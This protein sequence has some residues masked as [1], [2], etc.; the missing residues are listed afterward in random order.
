[1]RQVVSVRSNAV[2]AYAPGAAVYCEMVCNASSGGGGEFD[3]TA[4]WPV[5]GTI[6]NFVV[7]LKVPPGVGNTVTST[8][9]KAGTNQAVT[10][11]ISGTATTNRDVTNSFHIN[12]GELLSI[13]IT[14]TGTPAAPGSDGIEFVWEF[15]GD[16]A[17]ESGYAWAATQ[18][19]PG[20][21]R[22]PLIT[23][24]Y[25]AW[26][27]NA[28]STCANV[29]GTAGTITGYV[30]RLH[31]DSI[32]PGGEIYF[33]IYRST[34]LIAGGAF[35]KQD[36]TGGT[37]NCRITFTNLDG[38]P[39]QKS[40]TFTLP[41]LPGDRF[42]L[43]RTNTASNTYAAMVSGGVSFIAT[44]DGESMLCGIC[45]ADMDPLVTSYKK[46]FSD[47][48][49]AWDS[50][51]SGE[52]NQEQLGGV[53]SFTLSGLRLAAQGSPGMG[54]QYAL[55]LRRNNTSPAGTTR[56]VLADTATTA[57][58][59]T[60]AGLLIVDGDRFALRAVPS[61]TPTARAIAWA[62]TMGIGVN[63]PPVVNAGPDQAIALPVT[64]AL[65]AGTA[66]DDGL[67]LV[68]GALTITWTRTS[69]P[70]AVTFSDATSLTPLVT[71]MTAVGTYVLRLTVTDGALTVYDEMTVV[72][73]AVPPEIEFPAASSE[74]GL[75]W[76]EMYHVDAA[77]AP[78]TFLHAPVD[79]NDPP[80]YFGGYKEPRVLG[81]GEITRALSDDRGQ[82][83]SA[84]FSW[85]TSDTDRLQ[86]GWMANPFQRFIQNRQVIL[87]MISDAS[88][89]LFLTPR[90][91]VRGVIRG[92]K[93]RG[94]K[95]FE[96]RAQDFVTSLFGPANL[97]KQIPQEAIARAQF[98][99]CPTDA[100]G[101]PVPILFGKLS[102]DLSAS[103]PPVL[104]G[105]AARGAY[106][107][108]GGALVAGFGDLVSAASIPTNPTV[109][110]G[111]NGSG[112]LSAA[113]WN[114]Q[115][116]AMVTAVD[117]AGVETD[118]VPF[119]SD[120][121]NGGSRGSFA[122]GFP[123][124]YATVNGTQKVTVAWNASALA[125]KYRVY[126]GYYYY[127]F[128]PVVWKEVVA[129]TVTVDFTAETDGTLASFF[130][131]WTYSVSAVLPDG[132]T[133]LS[134][135][136][137][138]I[139]R[140]HR[141]KIRVQ[142]LAVATATAYR[143]RRKGATGDW[144]RQWE[145]AAPTLLFDDDLL[146]TGATF[147][148]GI[149]ALTGVV[150]VTY[151]G[152][153]Y[154][155]AGGA[156]HA[157]LVCGHQ[158]EAITAA[159]QDGVKIDVGNY[160]VTVLL[161]GETGY[162]TFF[163]THIGT[164]PY[165]QVNGRRYTKVYLRGPQGDAFADGSKPITLNLKGR[166]N[167]TGLFLEQL[168]D[169]YR[170][171]VV[172]FGFQDAGGGYLS[173]PNWPVGIDGVTTPQIDDASFALLKT[174]HALRLIGGYPGAIA[175]GLDGTFVTLR[176]ALAQLN[177]SADC[178]NGFNRNSQFFVSIFD[179]RP[180]VIAAGR[181]YT[182]V[183]DI[184][185]ESFDID[186]RVDD[187][188]NPVVYSFRKLYGAQ[189]DGRAWDIQEAEY[190]D[191]TAIINLRERRPG[192]VLDLYGVRNAAV[193]LDIARRRNVAKKEPPTLVE[194]KTTLQGLSTE[195]GD[196]ILVSHTDGASSSGWTLRPLRVRRHITNPQTYTVRM[197][198]EDVQRRLDELAIFG[199]LEDEAVM[200]GN[201]GDEL[202]LDAPLPGAYP[203]GD[204][205]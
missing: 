141:R 156:W 119:Y 23:G 110:A 144:D 93:P 64:Y 45:P 182:Q 4:P 170:E 160:G 49:G 40:A 117:A 17:K 161:P 71:G 77:N 99:R 31:A 41:C 69:G 97:Q 63:L 176:D 150:P 131:Q 140:T 20:T 154:D 11:T 14:A 113:I 120:G 127:G 197:V 61:A 153:E 166:R 9:R 59:P 198:C 158:V 121:P 126:L 28:G 112:T 187:V 102:N 46:L 84:E 19:N 43:E 138:G 1:M 89:R 167:S 149:A 103:A 25:V 27:T 143:I 57:S 87:R 24:S 115:W 175:F 152:I 145:V 22:L 114:A 70:T 56:A 85:V 5:P 30:I 54:R 101:K 80:F 111:A 181:P 135:E 62:L 200:D 108:G 86:R 98:P 185:K 151:I 50:S 60:S 204:E 75:S 136:V 81:F 6:D 34:P 8:V 190:E 10:T 100:V 3:V 134:Q 18:S 74:I 172:N 33:D 118:P 35:V 184:V 183:H 130:Q 139:V 90:T 38:A 65:M 199:P 122:N 147:I 13:E 94:P 191:G 48:A 165:H 164:P 132:E 39:W 83:E 188:E 107:D 194:L 82:Y 68:P 157:G 26:T 105:T 16:N 205:A 15:T 2:P 133:G 195:L 58:D 67:P 124:P 66:T 125:A 42:Y 196:V 202:S 37:P 88:R 12:A 155:V 79:L 203:L 72:V 104:T 174:I 201:L 52:D 179:E 146:D 7:R 168:A 78:K 92:F 36:G 116:G 128:R 186:P 169:I 192:R 180:A 163:P 173:V 47:N 177:V 193:A 148:T 106:D 171:F 91:L 96:Y 162:G 95:H 142:W 21:N 44:T 73:S 178:D 129:P 159:F 109:T 29:V 137:Y 32:D 55:D 53:T 76:V 189:A 123:L 51:A